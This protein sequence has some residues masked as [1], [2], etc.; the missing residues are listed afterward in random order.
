MLSGQSTW[1]GEFTSAEKPIL[2]FFTGGDITQNFPEK[3]NGGKGGHKYYRARR[4]G[5][6]WGGEA[7]REEWYGYGKRKRERQAEMD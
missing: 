2:D 5:G 7:G 1:V 6:L 3:Q 4:R